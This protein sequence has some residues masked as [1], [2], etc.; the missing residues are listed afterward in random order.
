MSLADLSPSEAG[1]G[2]FIR[3]QTANIYTV[4]LILSFVFVAVGCLFLFLEMK[5]YDGLTTKVAAEAKV[6]SPPPPPEPTESAAPSTEAAPGAT[7]AAGDAVP[8]AGAGA[9]TGNHS[10]PIAVIG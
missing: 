5:A 9:S 1:R 2:V 7:P 4:M 10:I 3:K 8:P 6:P